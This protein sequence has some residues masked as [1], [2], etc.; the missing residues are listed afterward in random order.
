[1]LLELLVEVVDLASGVALRRLLP[2]L[3]EVAVNFLGGCDAILFIKFES[4]LISHSTE[5]SSDTPITFMDDD[6]VVRT[7]PVRGRPRR[8]ILRS[9][10]IR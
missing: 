7:L 5:G 1:M 9:I 4:L 2:A 8:I 6:V 10:I 3:E